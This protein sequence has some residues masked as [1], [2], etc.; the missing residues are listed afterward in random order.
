MLM[1]CARMLPMLRIE[2]GSL[3][4]HLDRSFFAAK[5]RAAW[6]FL[7]AIPWPPLEQGEHSSLAKDSSAFRSGFKA[8]QA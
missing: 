8:E 4:K 1:V 2:V 3:L 7:L 6:L 5:R